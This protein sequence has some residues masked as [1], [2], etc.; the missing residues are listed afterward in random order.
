MVRQFEF[1]GL[2]LHRIDN[3]GFM[4]GTTGTCYNRAKNA[5]KGELIL[6][7][8]RGGWVNV[9]HGNLELLNDNDAIWFGKTQRMYR[10]LQAYGLEST[11]GAIPGT[12]KPYG[13]TVQGKEGTVSTVVNPSQSMVEID[14]PDGGYPNS[15]I[16]FAD[17]GYSPELSGQKILL[18]PEQLAVVGFGE[19]AGVKYDLG[20]DDTINIPVSIQEIKAEFKEIGLNKIEATIT[21]VAGKNIRIF[22]Q[23][24]GA[25]G[26]AKRS[27]GGAPPDGKKM[28]EYLKI[29]VIQD[30]KSIPLHIEY[31]KMLWCGLSWGAG[32]VYR[33]DFNQNKSLTIRCTSIE[34]YQ[35]KL[36]AEVY[37]TGY[38]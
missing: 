26:M 17:G 13:F 25:D 31:D 3:C 18:G 20:R 19:Y 30:G 6:S 23:Q 27:W 1:N 4:I 33:S 12:R 2:P 28:S 36:H 38:K 22:M 10:A 34:T 35:L 21:G 7:L 15:K 16:I 32:E 5:W 8:A 14:L 29:E 37:A 11:F 24:C 9:Y